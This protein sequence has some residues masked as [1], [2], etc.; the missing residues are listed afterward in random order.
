MRPIKS[1]ANV[2]EGRAQ[3][4]PTHLKYFSPSGMP[5]K[6]PLVKL[7]SDVIEECFE[8]WKNAL[9]G[10]FIEKRLPFPV[11]QNIAK[12]MWQRHRLL[13]VLSNNCHFFVFCFDSKESMLKF[14]M[15][16]FIILLTTQL[17]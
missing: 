7:Y 12:C 13:E 3:C 1:W 17:F 2:I 16:V 4:V 14:F 8:Y 5:S 15:W 9:V 11:V 6:I 10:Y